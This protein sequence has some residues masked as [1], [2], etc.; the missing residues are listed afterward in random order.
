MEDSV[1]F[2]AHIDDISKRGAR[3]AGWVLRTFIS[4]DSKTMLTL[5]KSLVL[6]I[7]EYCCQLWCPA[8]TGK[9]SKIESVQRN[10]TAQIA[11]M[12]ELNYWQRLKALKLYSLE[13]RRQRYIIIYVYKILINEVPNFEN[14]KYKICTY[15]NV[16]RGMLCRVPSVK[17]NAMAK[18]KTIKDNSFSVLGPK[19]FN[20]IPKELR[21]T[22]MS[23][24]VFKQKLDVFLMQI[25]DKPVMPNYPQPER[26]NSIICQ[27]ALMRRN[28]M[29]L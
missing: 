19:L 29:Y 7:L 6:P 15:Y 8:A 4:R 2:G 24:D 28:G 23:L 17:T 26:S 5:Y 20:S 3:Q 27:L 14:S 18:Y 11:G 10:F 12:G 25:D 21:Q 13:R 9:I 1:T 22:S 16:R